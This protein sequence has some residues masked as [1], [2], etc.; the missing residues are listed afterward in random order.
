MAAAGAQ[1]TIQA[2]RAKIQMEHLAGS[3]KTQLGDKAK[4]AEVEKQK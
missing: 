3:Q 2:V 1:S 4:G